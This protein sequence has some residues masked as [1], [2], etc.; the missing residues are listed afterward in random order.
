M[1]K[2]R[3]DNEATCSCAGFH[4]SCIA[5]WRDKNMYIRYFPPGGR[6]D[7]YGEIKSWKLLVFRLGKQR[8]CFTSFQAK[9]LITLLK[10]AEMT[11]LSDWL[12]EERMARVADGR[13]VLSFRCGFGAKIAHLTTAPCYPFKWCSDE[14]KCVY[15]Q[16]TFPASK[17]THEVARVLSVLLQIYLRRERNPPDF[18]KIRIFNGEGTNGNFSV[19]RWTVVCLFRN[20]IIDLQLLLMLL[21]QG[22][23][24]EKLCII[25]LAGL[26]MTFA[27]T[28]IYVQQRWIL[29]LINEFSVH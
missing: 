1:Q 19:V 29:P 20:A 27:K 3:P 9:I 17:L 24:C 16:P 5:T 2:N 21:Q 15:D 22:R 26:T 8:F 12:K 18:S 10:S 11:Y 13:F 25:T 28:L 14:L 23:V 7:I 4:C 6:P